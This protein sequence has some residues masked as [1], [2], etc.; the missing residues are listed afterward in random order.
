MNSSISVMSKKII[1]LN[2]AMTRFI[3]DAALKIYEINTLAERTEAVIKKIDM[4]FYDD[5]DS[6][7]LN[8]KNVKFYFENDT[9]NYDNMT[10]PKHRFNNY[11]NSLK[12]NIDCYFITPKHSEIRCLM[13]SY[14][15]VN[16]AISIQKPFAF[17]SK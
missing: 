7:L 11:S 8:L 13:G 5:Q 3:S 17:C 16:T 1:G 2:V 15:I 6:L 4:A 14:R 9:I 10:L 12:C